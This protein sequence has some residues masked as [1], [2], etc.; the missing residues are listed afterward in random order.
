MTPGAVDVAVDDDGPRAARTVPDLLAWRASLHPDRVAV[1]VHGRSRL[2]F[3]EWEAGAAAVAGALRGRGVGSG[4]RVGL[5]FGAPDWVDFAVAYCGV[6]RVG[7]VAVPLSDRL[8]PSQLDHALRHCGAVAVVHGAGDAP[9]VAAGSS[10]TVAALRREAGG[11]SEP[12]RARPADLA[13]ILYTSGTTGRPKGVAATHANLTFGATTHPRRLPLAHSERFLHAFAIGTNAGQTMLLNALTAKP[14]ALSLPLF[15]PVRF[16]RVLET[17]GVGSLFLVPSMAVELLDSGAL[18]GRSLDGVHLVGSTAAP[19]APAVAVRLSKA[20]PAATIV[21]YYTSTEAAPAQLAMIFDAARPAAVGRAV[22]GALRI[23]D[24]EGEP[25]PV[26]TVGEVWLRSPYPRAYLG[27]DAANRAVFRDDWVRMGDFGHVDADG[28]LYL[29]DRE[30]DLVKSGAFKVST[31]EVEAALHEH[32]HIA[33]AAVIGV[34]HP[35]LGNAVAAV[36]VARPD[37]PAPA[38]TLPALRAF[39]TERLADYQLPTRLL[40]V[41]HLPRN[42]AGKVLKRQLVT[43][44]AG[45]APG[46]EAAAP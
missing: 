20:F 10:A 28:Y 12:S 4:D 30:S 1:E 16:A 24:A 45:A 22:A 32:P 39:L 23:V 41:D 9:A 26:G 37:A 18:T 36:V 6:Q 2:T 25:V 13:Q 40:L 29:S 17:A 8:A 33:D 14:S 27:D 43:D 15:T 34:P 31:L 21:N 3:A 35:V 5:V 7:A 19:L 11:S 38:V 46:G 44:F 42:E